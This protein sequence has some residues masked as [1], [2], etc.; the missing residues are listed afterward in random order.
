MRSRRD[1][2]VLKSHRMAAIAAQK[3]QIAKVWVRAAGKCDVCGRYVYPPGSVARHRDTG[4][5]ADDRLLCGPHFKAV[6][7]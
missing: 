5:V 7:P 3:A 1:H 6:R 2:L 4:Y